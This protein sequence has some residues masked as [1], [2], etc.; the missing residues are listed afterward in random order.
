MKDISA[1]RQKRIADLMRE[2]GMSR[3]AAEFAEAI[4]AGDIP[5][6]VLIEDDETPRD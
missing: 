2:T 4:E 5:G 1:D 3:K 6:D